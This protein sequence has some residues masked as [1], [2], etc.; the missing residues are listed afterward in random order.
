M[1][2]SE[3]I[4]VSAPGEQEQES[5]GMTE[6]T[7]RKPLIEERREEGFGKMSHSQSR[8]QVPKNVA[9]VDIR[10]H[11]HIMKELHSHIIKELRTGS[12][13]GTRERKTK[14]NIM[15]DQES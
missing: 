15:K 1:R 10:L 12:F 4:V 13:E 3:E 5:E 14:K 6:Q 8:G 9:D 7:T 11:S 2:H